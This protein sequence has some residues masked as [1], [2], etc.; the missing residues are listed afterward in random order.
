MKHIVAIVL[1]VGMMPVTATD[2]A[3]PLEMAEIAGEW[4]GQHATDHVF[5]LRVNPDGTGVLAEVR[6]WD[7]EDEVT[8]YQIVDLHLNG[9]EIRIKLRHK[10]WGIIKLEGIA[11]PVGLNVRI[12]G[13]YTRTEPQIPLIRCAAWEGV[14]NRLRAAMEP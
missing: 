9:S 7:E 12:K 13:L 4:I 1:V 6:P 5:M 8:V 14:P 2:V 3:P 11:S 10:R